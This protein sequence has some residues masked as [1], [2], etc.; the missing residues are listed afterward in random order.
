[1]ATVQTPP[2]ETNEDQSPS[3]LQKF[4]H[5]Y[6]PFGE[7]PIS[8]AA[9]VSLHILVAVLLALGLGSLANRTQ[10][11]PSV[12]SVM[13]G[14]GDDSAPGFGEDGLP[15]GDGT[16]EQGAA[17]GAAGGGEGTGGGPSMPAP[18]V[19]DGETVNNV[20][21]FKP[22]ESVS[23]SANAA[24]SASRAVTAAQGAVQDARSRL[25]AAKAAL[26]KNLG[27]GG[28]GG[29]GEGGANGAGGGTGQGGGGGS[30]LKGRA[31]RPARW[32]LRF[33]SNS[34]QDYLAQFEGLGASFAFPAQ[35][36]NW[37]FFPK[38]S[39]SPSTSQI[40]DLASENQLYWVDENPQNVNGVARILG[41]QATGVMVT[42]LPR[43]LED[44]MLEMELSYRGLKEEDIQTTYF[45]ISRDG[46]KYDV[47][48]VDQ[49]AR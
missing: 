25:A 32:V 15:T 16:A 20:A 27:G 33:Q 31:A 8:S 47:K 17:A 29:P 12:S 41:V 34:T 40:K 22:T 24:D 26:A 4:W 2:P 14:D 19:T 11:P 45:G 38:P 23:T 5:R 35:G 30:G 6:S 48:V 37:Q 7:L 42:F 46:G 3:W 13:V 9:S 1:M 18:T 44:R 39:S 10:R 28:G 49:I 43:A 36:N 21:D